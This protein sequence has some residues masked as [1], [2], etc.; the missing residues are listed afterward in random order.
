MFLKGEP[1]PIPAKVLDTGLDSNDPAGLWLTYDI[2]SQ[3]RAGDTAN[4]LD[5]ALSMQ[6]ENNVNNKKRDYQHEHGHVGLC[7]G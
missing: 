6:S 4:F 3:P 1:H 2:K 7:P 5:E